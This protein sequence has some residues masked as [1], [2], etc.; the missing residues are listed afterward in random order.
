MQPANNHYRPDIDGLRSVAV[1]PVVLYHAGFS[2]F[3][4]GYVGV[5]IFF[6]I[7]GYLITSILLAEISNNRFSLSGFYARRARRLFPALFAMLLACCIPAYLLLMPGELE[8]FGESLATTAIFSSNF[9]F[10]SEAGYFEGPAE[11][12]PLLHTW[13]LAIEEQYYLLFPGVLLLVQRKFSGR[14]LA[15][16]MGLFAASLALSVWSVAQAPT[17]GF[18]LLP[19]RTWELLLGSMLAMWLAGDGQKLTPPAWLGES[20]AALGLALIAFAIFA[21]QPGIAFPGLAAIPPCLGTALIIYAGATRQNSVGRLLSLRPLV[22]IGLISYS[23]YLWHW[24]LLVFA[25]H[26]ALR[27]LT[28]VEA[29]ILVLVAVLLATLSWRYVEKPFRG[30]DALVTR[31]G[32]F[33]LAGVCMVIA[34]AFGL[35]LDKTEGLPNRLDP[36]TA[37]IAAVAEEKPAS[38]KTCQGFAP[39]QVTVD[40]LCP[41]N[42]SEVDPSVLIWGDSHAAMLMD[43]LADAT[44]AKGI[45]G[46]NATYKGCAPLLGYTSQAGKDK[47]GCLAFNDKVFELLLAHPEIN[48]VYLVARWG[49]YVDPAP[50]L[51]ESGGYF[52]LYGDGKRATTKAENRAMFE[53]AVV[54]TFAK[55]QNLPQRIVVLAGNPEIGYDVPIVLGKASMLGRELN[56]DVPRLEYEQRQALPNQ[57]FAQA[58]AQEQIDFAPIHQWLCDE[59]WC[60]ATR[61]GLPIYNDDDHLSLAGARLLRPFFDRELD[62]GLDP[63]GTSKH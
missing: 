51:N 37:S 47:T 24:P 55:L 34:I 38:R 7:S 10:F 13:S 16:T 50:Y 30:T 46:L 28:L 12:K 17:A 1:V 57:L 40:Q 54:S 56:L 23:L 42:S 45:N 44:V 52:Y 58:A 6:V 19:S 41:L 11:M 8:D 22:F 18:Y 32:L 9:L 39:S 5:D 60:P 3:S 59:S 2:L 26:Y 29:S 15:A 62:S 20:L 61:D 49:R 53:Q 63:I 33:R 14:F 48:T 35:V 31:T 4:G 21:Y 36:V 25:K 43:M 27:E